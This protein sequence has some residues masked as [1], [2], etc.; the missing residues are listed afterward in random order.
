MQRFSNHARSIIEIFWI[1][2][3]MHIP[4]IQYIKHIGTGLIQITN[5]QLNSNKTYYPCLSRLTFHIKTIILYS[6]PVQLSIHVRFLK[7]NCAHQSNMTVYESCRHA[8][9]NCIISSYRVE[10]IIHV[11]I[12]CWQINSAYWSHASL[13]HAYWSHVYIE[14]MP[15]QGSKWGGMRRYV[16]PPLFIL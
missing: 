9:W 1:V 4:V 6:N 15:I 11:W 7:S 10:H 3:I 8:L 2:Q 12:M 13:S 16:I 5:I 14:V